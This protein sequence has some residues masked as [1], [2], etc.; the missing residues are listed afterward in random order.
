MFWIAAKVLISTGFPLID[1]NTVG[2]TEIIDLSNPTFKQDLIADLPKRTNAIGGLIQNK[3][4][5]I[6]GSNISEE[7]C[8][9]GVIIGG[10]PYATKVPYSSTKKSLKNTLTNFLKNDSFYRIVC[11]T[12]RPI[13]QHDLEYNRRKS[14]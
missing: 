14:E 5:M 4:I 1:D 9:D 10:H 7:I 11:K 8:Q 6:G 12:M 3:P 13:L 2:G